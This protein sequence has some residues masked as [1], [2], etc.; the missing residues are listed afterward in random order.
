MFFKINLCVEQQDIKLLRYSFLSPGFLKKNMSYLN[1][2]LIWQRFSY[3]NAAHLQVC[4]LQ[5]L[6]FIYV[7]YLSSFGVL[8]NYDRKVCVAQKEIRAPP[9]GRVAYCILDQEQS[10]FSPGS[11]RYYS[12]TVCKQ[13]MKPMYFNVAKTMTLYWGK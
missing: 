9:R 12:F 11:Y 13:D 3:R 10:L 8:R 4:G 7:G 6:F 5:S 2:F 1:G